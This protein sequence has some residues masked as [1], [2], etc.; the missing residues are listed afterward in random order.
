M[1]TSYL[2]CSQL[3]KKVDRP[4]KLKVSNEDMLAHCH[5]RGRMSTATLH[6]S[7]RMNGLV[8]NSSQLT[9][10]YRYLKLNFLYSKDV[11]LLHSIVQ[12]A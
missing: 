7:T 5:S 3:A 6:L 12:L 9:H 8:T 1:A 2:D 10:T 4:V 11:K